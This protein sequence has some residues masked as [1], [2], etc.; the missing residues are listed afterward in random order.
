ML[1]NI[2]GTE[3]D[4][5]LPR[6]LEEA[7]QRIDELA[8]VARKLEDE[9]RLLPK[10]S[11]SKSKRK[12]LSET[13]LELQI[14]R[15]WRKNA[16]VILED[17]LS[18][19]GIVNSK[20]LRTEAG[21]IKHLYREFRNLLAEHGIELEPRS[22][23]ATVLAA[24][25]YWLKQHYSTALS[26]KELVQDLIQ[27]EKERLRQLELARIEREKAETQQALTLIK[28]LAKEKV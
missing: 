6:S 1:F 24:A 13:H 28:R 10:S 18:K 2:R 19:S 7:N 17:M 27:E 9:V 14:L 20:E 12:A 26:E 21:L 15:R 5:V 11:I 22:D 8:I 4:I 16:T 25:Q 23:R 3:I